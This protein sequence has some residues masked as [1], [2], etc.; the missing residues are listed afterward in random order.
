MQ[1]GKQRETLRGRE[2]EREQKRERE[3][4]N[5][6]GVSPH[7][8]VGYVPELISP[9]SFCGAHTYTQTHDPSRAYQ[10]LKI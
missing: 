8:L 10:N 1:Y 7:T 2:R 9:L 4:F 3:L 5:A 6:V